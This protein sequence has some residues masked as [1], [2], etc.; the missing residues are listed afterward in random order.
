MGAVPPAP[1]PLLAQGKH[2]LLHLQWGAAGAVVRTAGTIH[3][4]C[5]ALLPI[6]SHPLAD[7]VAG[8]GEPPGR[9]PEAAALLPGV[10][11]IEAKA[12]FAFPMGELVSFGEHKSQKE[13]ILLSSRFE[14]AFG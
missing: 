8:A 2:L 12:H 14:A 5:F 3:K 9:F 11:D 7:G 4:A 10:D 1:T 6:A 13:R